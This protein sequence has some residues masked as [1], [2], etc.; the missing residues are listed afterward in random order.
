MKKIIAAILVLTL[1]LTVAS[2][3]M[4]GDANFHIVTDSTSVYTV[5]HSPVDKTASKWTIRID[6]AASNLSSTHRAV[7]RVHKGSPAISATYVFTEN[8]YNN[9]GY[10]QGYTGLV[11]GI[12]FR[13]KLDDRD[14]GTLEFHG[15]FIY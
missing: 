13:S 8:T 15:R 10:K 11:S 7:A 5:G 1:V 2:V 12:T 14:S 6:V 3:A 9:Y 4:A